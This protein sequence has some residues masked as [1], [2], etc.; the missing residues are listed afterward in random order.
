[1]YTFKPKQVVADFRKPRG[2]LLS[3]HRFLRR[4]ATIYPGVHINVIQ[5]SG[6][7]CQGIINV[8]YLCNINK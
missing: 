4:D 7:L 3:I 1:M 2:Q 8:Y 5:A 6:R